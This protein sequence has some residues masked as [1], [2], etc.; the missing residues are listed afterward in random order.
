MFALDVGTM[1]N[2]R[3]AALVVLAL[4]GVDPARAV[5]PCEFSHADGIWHLI[6]SHSIVR[7]ARTFSETDYSETEVRKQL[8]KPDRIQRHSD[9]GV[10]LYWVR[11][12]WRKSRTDD[13]DGRVATTYTVEYAVLELSF[14]NSR[15][16]GC[17]VLERNFVSA[18]RQPDVFRE[19]E[20]LMPS[21]LR[22][23]SDFLA[24]ATN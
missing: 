16:D 10:S 24:N 12:A 19:I 7:E 22:T 18:R 2:S 5:A 20:G 8:G 3:Q 4:S 13:C 17:H 11:G 1:P 14:R 9:G 21:E 15:Q 6:N 23:C